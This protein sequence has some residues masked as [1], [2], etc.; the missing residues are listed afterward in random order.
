MLFY[1]TLYLMKNTNLVKTRESSARTI[2]TTAMMAA[3]VCGIALVPA[4]PTEPVP[5]TMQV[6]GILLAPL[7]L[8]L[9]GAASVGIY[10]LIGAAGVPVF[11]KGASG[12]GAIVGATGGFIIGFFLAALV[13]GFV[14]NK[15]SNFF[16]LLATAI[17][18][19]LIIYGVG[20][21]QLSVVTKMSLAKAFT[22]GAAP[23]IL[24][25]V[26]KAIVASLLA[27]T[28]SKRVKL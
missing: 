24:I 7:L 23:F 8:G 6:L 16:V 22:V 3:V 11:A 20:V 28:I 4:I 2:A 18:S 26:I 13:I 27:E 12:I 19:L 25:D 17:L 1:A 15:T 5:F 9:R 14:K 21:I 10:I